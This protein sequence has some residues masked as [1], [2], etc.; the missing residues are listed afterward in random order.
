MSLEQL[1]K[2]CVG[3]LTANGDAFAMGA[4]VSIADFALI[5][6]FHILL[7]AGYP[8]PDKLLG[9]WVHGC[10]YIL[11]ASPRFPKSVTARARAC[12]FFPAAHPWINPVSSPTCCADYLA[13]F[14]SVVPALIELEEPLCVLF[15]RLNSGDSSVAADDSAAPSKPA[16]ASPPLPPRAAAVH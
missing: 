10:K 15:Q 3:L 14:A 2:H 13:S 4:D 8:L 5:P 9:A 1:V 6:A 11:T 7:L 16:A 12:L